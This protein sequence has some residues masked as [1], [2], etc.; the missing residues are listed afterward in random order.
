MK[1]VT[2]IVVGLILGLGIGYFMFGPGS[3]GPESLSNEERKEFIAFKG[4]PEV[5][6][7]RGEAI[8]AKQANTRLKAMRD[9]RD[10]LLNKKK[11]EVS[12]GYA[13]GLNPVKELLKKIDTLNKYQ[14]HEPGNPITGIRAHLS[15]IDTLDN[16][17]KQYKFLD[18]FL[19]PVQQN[20][21]NYIY[22]DEKIGEKDEFVDGDDLILNQSNP[23][24]EYCDGPTKLDNESN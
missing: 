3:F 2:L 11:V 16:D 6:I 18:V 5:S 14:R 10:K 12:S 4:G 22:I 20:G 1:H 15:L 9:W 21:R 19:S 24:P 23:C 17:G 7:N 8:S 13:F